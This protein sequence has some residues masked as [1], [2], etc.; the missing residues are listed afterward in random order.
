MTDPSG[1]Q[2]PAPQGSPDP[3]AGQDSVNQA[4]QPATD[5]KWKSQLPADFANSPTLKPYPDTKEGFTNAI[6]SHLSLEKLLGHEKIPVPKGKDD[7]EGWNA[8]QKAFG[9]PDKPDGYNLEDAKVPDH[10]KG[11]TFD[12][13]KFAEIIHKNKLT[14]D[15]A[16]DLWKSYTQMTTQIYENAVKSQKEK[17]TA[18]INQ[19]RGEWGDAY[20]TKVELGQ[21]VINK[22]SDNQEMN[23]YITSVLASDPMG[24]KFL[25]KIGDQF[26][27]NKIGEFKNAKYSLTPEEAQ[28]EIDEIRRDPNHPYNNDRATQ[29]ERDRAID[30]VNSLIGITKKVQR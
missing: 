15:Q 16:K 24:I 23:D 14:P 26:A 22:F 29:A 5:F 11:M 10:I 2:D 21:M 8:F 20:Q 27:E 17:M 28:K 19:M 12:K 13:T 30:Y 1:S 4:P 25:A 3:N 6:K 18:I 9:I 7:V